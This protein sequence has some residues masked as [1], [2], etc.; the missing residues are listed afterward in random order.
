MFTGLSNLHLKGCFIATLLF[1]SAA[2]LPAQ[3]MHVF[4]DLFTDSVYYQQEG[5]IVNKPRIKKGDRVV[6]HFTEFNPYL[7]TAS[8][9]IEQ[10]NTAEWAGNTGLSAFSSMVPGLGNLL[11]G[12]AVADTSRAPVISFLDA[13]LMRLGQKSFA[14]KDLFSNSRGPAQM[15]EQA[16]AQLQDLSQIQAEMSEIYQE[17]KVLE[18]S[19]RVSHLAV[20]HLDA[21]LHNPQLRPSLIKRV[22]TEYMELVFPGKGAS[23][24][25]VDD[26]F[27]WE[28]RTL[29]KGRLLQNLQAKQT[30]FE[31]HMREL[32]PLAQQL[33]D[34]DMGSEELETFARDLS[35]LKDSG[36]T[37]GRQVDAFIANQSSNA[38]NDLSLEELMSL[39]LRFRELASMSFSYDAVVIMEKE[40]ADLTATFVLRDTLNKSLKDAEKTPRVKTV[41]LESRGG[42]RINTS[43]GVSFSQFF[44]PEQKFS[45]RNNQVVA[46][47]G[48][49]IQPTLTTFMHF[50][51]TGRKGTTVGGT[52]GLGIPLNGGNISAINFFL[53]PSLLFGQSQRIILSGGLCAGPVDRLAKGFKVGDAFDP[54]NGDIPLRSRY[55]LGYFMGISFGLGR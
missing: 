24:L 39:Q 47:D 23:G 51:A 44:D 30:D 46:D 36:K 50:Y 13:P 55:E 22:V 29:A 37:M 53:G 19:Q 17:I 6:V 9:T 31:T 41:Q 12:S 27:A 40:V 16:K 7:Y 8:F 52:F 21:L 2:L 18:K 3:D 26:A 14:L 5:K 42:L 48:N 49:T 32:G 1:L 15:L 20:K 54:A 10:Y 34:L 33:G 11:P 28:E 38:Q 4:Y 35:K 43:F 45:V 25:Q